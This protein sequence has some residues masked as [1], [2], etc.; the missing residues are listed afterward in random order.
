MAFTDFFKPQQPKQQP[1][2][3]P[4]QQQQQFGT[5]NP[6]NQPSGQGGATIPNV[7]NNGGQQGNGQNP[8]NQPQ[9]N[10]LDTY[11]KMF[12]NPGTDADKAP[13]FTIDPKIMDQVVSSQD[14]MQ[15]VDPELMQKATS[16]D[17][18]ALV[19][20]IQ[21]TSRNAYRASIEHGGMLTDKFV[22]SRLGFE[23]KSLGSRVK[24]ELTMNSLSNTPN[25]QHPVV[26]RQ[27][28]EIA[29]RL[30]QANPDATPQEIAEASKKYLSDLAAALNPTEKQEQ[31]PN[32]SGERGE[33]FWSDFF[34][35]DNLNG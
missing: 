17:M 22:G 18:Q 29:Q 9:R 28:T 12:D 31:N 15:G 21:H 14:F 25:Y 27:L 10:P 2:Q 24:Q 3:Q 20:L 1:Q 4:Q 6:Q 32:P 5:P 19:Q 7:N 16:G 35:K 23:N 13:S 33:E 11:S 8:Q 26:K 34:E 30:Q